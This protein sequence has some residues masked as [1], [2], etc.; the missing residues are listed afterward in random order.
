MFIDLFLPFGLVALQPKQASTHCSL[1]EP[2]ICQQMPLLT[3][4]QQSKAERSFIFRKLFTPVYNL[5]YSC[6]RHLRALHN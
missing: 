6:F 4:P 1:D 5:E 2:Y 3:K